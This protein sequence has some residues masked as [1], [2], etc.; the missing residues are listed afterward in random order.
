MQHD[1][2]LAEQTRGAQGQQFRI[3]G[4]GP[5]QKNFTHE[6]LHRGGMS[7]ARAYRGAVSD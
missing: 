4:A 5:D 6:F 1:I 7:S 2:C 3:A